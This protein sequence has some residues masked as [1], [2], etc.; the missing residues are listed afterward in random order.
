MGK[1]REAQKEE[2][3]RREAKAKAKEERGLEGGLVLSAVRK[4][5]EGVEG[6]RRE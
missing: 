1:V 2:V 5:K 4:L 6:G 3:E